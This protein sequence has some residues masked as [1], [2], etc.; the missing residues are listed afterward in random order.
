M[1]FLF[2][3]SPCPFP[4]ESSKGTDLSEADHLDD[5]EKLIR[6][7]TESTSQSDIDFHSLVA[8]YEGISQENAREIGD[9]DSDDYPIVIDSATS[10]TIT[11]YFE[12]LIDPKP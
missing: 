1:L 2:S 8:N 9:W 3:C 5:V 12:D 10:R 4:H 7:M 11:P 6:D